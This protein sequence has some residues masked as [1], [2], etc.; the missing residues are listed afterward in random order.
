MAKPRLHIYGSSHAKNLYIEDKQVKIVHPG[1][2]LLDFK[3][4]DEIKEGVDTVKKLIII[5]GSNDIQN[6]NKE[7][8]DGAME[9]LLK[10][11]SYLYI[12]RV[13]GKFAKEGYCVFVLPL[14]RNFKEKSEQVKFDKF[15]LSLG[16]MMQELRFHYK[17]NIATVNVV[18]RL[19]D[20]KSQVF[21]IDGV[22]L[23][24]LGRGILEKEIKQEI[25][26]ILDFSE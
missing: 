9:A 16:D 2:K 7:V 18:K 12:R 24:K 10:A 21:R 4:W 1:G 15:N 14:P 23:N 13:Q 3:I 26:N 25:D 19:T 17:A 8:Q 6:R 22:H 11:F 20:L 5:F